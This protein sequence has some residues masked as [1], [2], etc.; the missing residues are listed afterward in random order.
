[1][2][3]SSAEAEVPSEVVDVN[4]IL[5]DYY[6][7]HSRFHLAPHETCVFCNQ[8]MSVKVKV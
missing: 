6:E 3:A 5:S 8:Y 2:S 4:D 7:D 1:M